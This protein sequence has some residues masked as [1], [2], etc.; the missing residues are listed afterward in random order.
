MFILRN[1]S[2]SRVSQDS[3][4]FLS[5]LNVSLKQPNGVA[6]D[7][8]RYD[9]YKVWITSESLVTVPVIGDLVS[10]G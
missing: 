2:V 1:L 9:S 4:Y 10:Y 6:T 5:K 3:T 8:V 7:R